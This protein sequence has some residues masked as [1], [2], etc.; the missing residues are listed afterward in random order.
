MPNPNPNQIVFDHAVRALLEQGAP[1]FDFNTNRCTY[2]DIKTGNRCAIGHC[3]PE[4]RARHYADAEFSASMVRGEVSVHLGLDK[5]P[6]PDFVDDL[7]WAHDT[8][9]K[10]PGPFIEEFLPRARDVAF[11]FSLNPEVTHVPS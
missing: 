3:M 5:L 1:G 2:F 4:D 11:N 9:A 10:S 8:T 6:D 7:Q